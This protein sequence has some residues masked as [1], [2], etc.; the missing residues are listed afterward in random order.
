MHEQPR[1]ERASVRGGSLIAILALCALAAGCSRAAP[2]HGA[3]APASSPVGA[4][5]APPQLTT[6]VRQAGATSLSGTATPGSVIRLASPDGSTITGAVDRGGVWRLSAPAGDAPRLYSLSETLG[7]RLVRATGY[8]AVLPSPGP[9][10]AMLHPAAAAAMTP[11]DPERGITAIDYDSSGAAVASGRAAPGEAIRLELDGAEA[12]DDRADT[13]GMFS[14][15]LSRP[16]SAGAHGLRAT[17]Q[18]LQA[19]V[20]FAAAPPAHVATPPFA[21][22]RV[23]GAWRID[24]TP[25][26]GGVQSTLLFDHKGA[27]P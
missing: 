23:D 6:A 10:A 3:A 7:G 14:A 26:G 18:H 27:R 16:L 9:A 24:W 5:L 22:Q 25:P 21:A 20:A 13:R 1:E 2:S 8:L 19:G 11:S 4:Y 12:G 15:V 17:G